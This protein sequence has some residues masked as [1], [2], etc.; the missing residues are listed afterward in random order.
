MRAAFRPQARVLLCAG[1]HG[2]GAARGGDACA[3]R[4]RAARLCASRDLNLEAGSKP[5]AQTTSV[6]PADTEELWRQYGALGGAVTGR[7]G[8]LTAVERRGVDDS[9]RAGRKAGVACAASHGTAIGGSLCC[10]QRGV[11]VEAR[12]V[13]PLAQP[14]CA[15]FHQGVRM[16]RCTEPAATSSTFLQTAAPRA[17]RLAA[18]ERRPRIHEGVIRSDV[19][20]F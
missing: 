20:L 7:N 16:G 4:A 17:E 19:P 18:V 6:C 3:E 2:E 10:G 12:Q 15:G 9:A 14:I 1:S 11:V 13:C 5:H 8:A